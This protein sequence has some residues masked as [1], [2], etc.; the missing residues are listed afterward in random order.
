MCL[1]FDKDLKLYSVA[2]ACK[3]FAGTH[4]LDRIAES[5][6]EIHKEF[7]IDSSKLLA[8]IIDRGSNFVKCFKEF[9]LTV[10]T[11]DSQKYYFINQTMKF[12]INWTG[13]VKM[14]ISMSFCIEYLER[15]IFEFNYG[16]TEHINYITQHLCL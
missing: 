16:L 2:L 1:W 11:S 13:E 4:S 6:N 5:L 9:G 10:I 7:Q 14:K 15:Q 8:T 12:Q 3:R